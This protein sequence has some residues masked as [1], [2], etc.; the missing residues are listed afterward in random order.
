MTTLLAAGASIRWGA[1]LCVG[2]ARVPEPDVP[3]ALRASPFSLAGSDFLRDRAGVVW[4][5][6]RNLNAVSVWVRRDC[7]LLSDRL[8]AVD[9]AAGRT[10][11]L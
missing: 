3:S 11:R 8:S 5:A 7:E 10:E 2:G 9:T 1:A 6:S 4:A